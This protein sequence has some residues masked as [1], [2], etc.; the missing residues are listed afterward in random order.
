MK[1][2]LKF[3]DLLSAVRISSVD[4]NAMTTVKGGAWWV[5]IFIRLL[6]P[7][8]LSVTGPR[9]HAIVIF[10]R[11]SAKIALCQGIKGLVIHLKAAGV[12]LAQASGDHMIK[13]VSKLNCRVSRTN[14]GIPR[15]ILASDRQRIRNG[16]KVMEKFY[17]S[18]FSLYGVLSFPGKVKVHTITAPFTGQ[19]SAIADVIGYIP[20]FVRALHLDVFF[21]RRISVMKPTEEDL[22]PAYSPR[23]RLITGNTV[24]IWLKEQ[25]ENLTP[26]WIRRSAMGTSHDGPIEISTHPILMIR[27]AISI[28]RSPVYPAFRLLMTLLPVNSRFTKA[29]DAS[30]K[31]AGVFKPLFTLGKIGL[32]DEAAGKVRAFAMVPGWF[33]LLLKPIHDMLFEILRNIRQD[34]TFDQ[35]RPLK[36]HYP[37][38]KEAYSLDL[39][40]ATDRLP[41][42]IQVAL[43]G[44]IIGDKTIAIAWGYL[45]TGIDYSLNSFKYALNLV[46]QY[47]VGQP[48]GALS[49]WPS[50]AI[51][52]HLL[53]Q[54]SSWKAAVVPVGVWFK[55]YAVLG[56]DL[57]IFN[58]AVAEEYLKLLRGLGMEV[59]L[60]K[61]LLCRAGSGNVV[62]E[63]AKR[64]FHN[65]IDV[66][67][68]RV[69][70]FLAALFE[71]PRLLAFRDKYNLSDSSVLKLLG[72][73]YQ[74][75][76]R[77][78]GPFE[79]L[80]YKIKAFK[81][82][83][84]LP[85][86]TEGITSLFSLGASQQQ[87]FR[88]N[89][90]E[91]LKHFTSKEF[92][93]LV[94]RMVKI[95]RSHLN[96]TV[97]FWNFGNILKKLE[98]NGEWGGQIARSARYVDYKWLTDQNFIFDSEKVKFE[99]PA[100]LK[101]EHWFISAFNSEGEPVFDV[102][103]TGFV[104]HVAPGDKVFFG[105][106]GPRLG[107]NDRDV[108][109]LLDT[110]VLPE[111]EIR[112]A[113]ACLVDLF[114]LD[115]REEQ[116]ALA[117]ELEGLARRGM[118]V[119]P[120]DGLEVVI[121]FIE[122]NREL[123]A[124]APELVPLQRTAASAHAVDP[125]GIKIW[126]RWSAFIQGT[127]SLPTATKTK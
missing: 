1:N 126:K 98:D 55:D 118:F 109:T 8:G 92:R 53:V 87:L 22:N 80:N 44:E 56:D 6:Q 73:K 23:I 66:S 27:S 104:M 125:I 68:V 108:P 52:H 77:L 62:I 81:V 110:G 13:D 49:S 37:K 57:V 115:V 20:Y 113:L 11:R 18:L 121:R 103:Q 122:I 90:Y 46:V 100:E 9:V 64:I 76:S 29:F 31:L 47:A 86:T 25:Y 7:I 127:K 79:N 69:T 26:L 95:H 107:P 72:F 4:V 48:M 2:T 30:I 123:G 58:K 61:S 88:V 3:K 34:G 38:Y 60:H 17:H 67:P 70:E 74:A 33:Q 91:V 41:I 96:S 51:T 84:V 85:T 94:D 75:L 120:T 21:A 15:L 36:G 114:V 116:I 54:V 12:C 78:N 89:L 117:A 59:G 19:E 50:L 105:E 35:L 106:P 16:D 28:A 65:G 124:L 112:W 14:R 32:K 5:K 40:A 45:L 82:A 101:E 119:N 102:G 83:S 24:L 43:L 10:F 111:K 97:P 93:V 63:F 71:W 39:T 99:G 42:K